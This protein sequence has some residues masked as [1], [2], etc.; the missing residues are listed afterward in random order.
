MK[1]AKKI[2]AIVT[3]PVLI[4]GLV[5]FAVA[6]VC[7]FYRADRDMIDAFRPVGTYD[8][9]EDSHGNLIFDS[10]GADT[11]FIFYPGGKVEK[12]AYIP[13]MLLLADRG[14]KCVLLDITF[15]LAILDMDAARGIAE[16][17]PEINT[18]YVGGHSLGG[19]AAASF[20]SQNKVGGVVLLAS[21]PTVDISDMPVASIFGSRDGVMNREK[22]EDSRA[23]LPYD[24]YEYVIDGGNHSGFAMYGEQ[25]GDYETSMD[26]DEQIIITSEIILSFINSNQ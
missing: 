16:E 1:L 25:D 20:A 13:L 15:N 5:V 4:F 8:Y 21:Y 22:Y 9:S 3:L 12:E 19:V 7:D 18:W 11:G 17:H 10:E 24:L 26:N 23:L 2:V 6:Y 14:I